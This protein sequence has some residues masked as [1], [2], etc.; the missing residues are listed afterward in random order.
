MDGQKIIVFEHVREHFFE[1]YENIH[2]V[3][4]F[5]NAL[6]PSSEYEGK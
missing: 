6:I 2:I 5:N 4:E 3:K 1:E